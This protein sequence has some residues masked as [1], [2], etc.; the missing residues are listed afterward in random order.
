MLSYT[1]K[2]TADNTLKKLLGKLSID[3]NVTTYARA[4]IITQTHTQTWEQNTKYKIN[5]KYTKGK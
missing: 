3:I 4:K 1:V 5:N 2:N